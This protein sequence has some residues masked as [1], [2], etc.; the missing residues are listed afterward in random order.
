MPLYT[1]FHFMRDFW[2]FCF[3]DSIISYHSRERVIMKWFYSFSLYQNDCPVPVNSFCICIKYYHFLKT[4]LHFGFIA[5]LLSLF[6]SLWNV[7]KKLCGWCTDC[8]IKVWT[9][10]ETG[11]WPFT[12]GACSYCNVSWLFCFTFY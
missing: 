6:R 7:W 2:V 1:V 8:P 11:H 10:Q 12:Y 9:A 4:K 3:M 5:T